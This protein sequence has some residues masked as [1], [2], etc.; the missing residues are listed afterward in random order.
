MKSRLLFAATLI[1]L[2]CANKAAV[3]Q[4]VQG[5]VVDSVSQLPLAG[6]AVT[7]LDA[8]DIEVARTLTDERGLFLLRAID[9]GNLR[10][11]VEQVGYRASTFP[12]FTLAVGDAKEFILLVASTEPPPARAGDVIWQLC[13]DSTWQRGVLIGF[14]RKASPGTPVAEASVRVS[15]PALPG[16]LA[17]LVGSGDVGRV[18][19]EVVTDS[20]GVY[21]V[22]GIPM[23]TSTMFHAVSGDFLSNFVEVRFDSGG[24]SVSG[25]YHATDAPLLRQDLQL[26][27]PEERTAA[28][29]GTVIDAKTMQPVT[30]VTV[31]IED[32]VLQTSTD[33][34]GTFQ[35]AALPP[36]PARLTVRHP[37]FRPIIWDLEL[38]EEETITL[39]PGTLRLEALRMELT[40]IV[41]ESE[42]RS[43][44]RLTD[45]WER[46]EHAQGSFITRE[47][48]EKQGNPQRPTDVLRRMA[49]IRIVPNSRYGA[50]SRIRYWVQM[51]RMLGPRTFEL[52]EGG[53][54]PLYFLDR[55]YI[56]K[57]NE[58]DIDAIL[59]LVDVEAVEAYSGLSVP[60]EFARR[61]FQC[62]VIAFW[63]R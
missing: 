35:L 42:Q 37:G 55:H 12:P 7:L 19:R 8:N 16:V 39:R 29:G 21:V 34:A 63:T 41:V 23:Q 32:T 17:Q 26:A 25:T 51:S 50:Q 33:S 57:S 48:F 2:I 62:G 11:R 56:G 1:A 58:V 3:G 46:R 28:V 54:F 15:W 31:K 27:P 18:L 47:E 44:R 20:A 5:Q 6:A 22:C 52:Q 30:G 10:L 38:K 60:R 14:V 49:G 36:G 40:P 24:V 59:P 45:F 43:R 4:I 61:G 9:A 53:C 13:A